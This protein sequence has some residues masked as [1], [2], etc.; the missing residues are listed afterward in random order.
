MAAQFS[1]LIQ[2]KYFDYLVAAVLFLLALAYYRY[3]CLTPDSLL[4]PNTYQSRDIRRAID[5]YMNHRV[6]WHG[7]ELSGGGFL[8]GPFYYFLI[9]LPYWLTENLLSIYWFEYALI[10]FGLAGMWVFMKRK[11]AWQPAGVFY[12]LFLF[13]PYFKQQLLDFMNPSFQFLFSFI[14]LI[15][16]LQKDKWWKVVVGSL[17]V[18]L[19]IQIHYTSA[20]LIFAFL[21]SV[22]FDGE[23]SVRKKIQYILTLIFCLVLVSSGY[24]YFISSANHQADTD[25]SVYLSLMK[26]IA[27]FGK[28]ATHLRAAQVYDF[29]RVVLEDFYVIPSLVLAFLYLKKNRNERV[30]LGCVL[31]CG[32]ALLARL[33]LTFGISRYAIPFFTVSLFIFSVYLFQIKKAAIRKLLLAGCAL[34]AIYNFNAAG[35]PTMAAAGGA[36]RPLKLSEQIELARTIKSETNWSFEYFRAHSFFKGLQNWVDFTVTYPQT[37]STGEVHYDGMFAVRKDLGPLLENGRL[38]LNRPPDLLPENI[39]RAIRQNELSCEKTAEI[40]LFEICFYRFKNRNEIRTWGNIGYSYDHTY[41]DEPMSGQ[42]MSGVETHGKNSATVFNNECGRVSPECYVLFNFSLVA[43][44]KLKLEILGAP[45]AVLDPYN[46]PRWAWYSAKPKLVVSC[47]GQVSEYLIATG[48]GMDDDRNSFTTPFN[49]FFT[50]PCAQPESLTLKM[51]KNVTYNVL[52]GL[53]KS[54]SITK[55]QKTW[56]RTE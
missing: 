35:S 43:D 24:I 5:L 47:Q 53:F 10:S 23:F 33:L 37:E 17:A 7:P 46:L 41:P 8:P 27:G 51:D 26:I 44:A 49:E 25:S 4:A 40:G 15:C 21:L 56:V 36:W 19:A 45:L 39:E 32:L 29:I 54:Y 20:V 42:N 18:G 3:I 22:I 38:S 11:Y 30:F 55:F 16:F 48:L 34:Y 52:K 9:G 50:L 28:F 14:A 12:I 1:K 31:V 13:S 2:H 6:V